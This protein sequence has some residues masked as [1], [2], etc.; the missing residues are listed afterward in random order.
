MQ[1]KLSSLKKDWVLT[2]E[3]LDLLLVRLDSDRERAAEK[4][5][6]L[7][8]MLITFFDFRDLASPEEKADEVINRM[9]RRISEGQEID[10]SSPSTYAYAVARNVWREHLSAP[11]KIVSSLD[12][13]SNAHSLS[14]N[15]HEIGER[16]LERIE[17]EKRLEC[18]DKCLEALS[19]EIREI[20]IKYYQGDGE[21][22]IKT[23]KQLADN[24][25][26][27]LGVLRT[28]ACRLREKLESC[29]MNCLRQRPE[30]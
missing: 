6:D 24:L 3:A 25:G 2:Q 15:P 8:R 20:I 21:E 18:L 7:R 26:I 22:K 4:Y 10:R 28:R 30:Q 29:V 17:Y 19:P 23:R 13:V 1:T 27:S 14:E 9:A 5:E 11:S 12:G 16:N